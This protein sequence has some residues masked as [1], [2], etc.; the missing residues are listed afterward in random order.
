MNNVNQKNVNIYIST[1]I[2]VIYMAIFIWSRF[3]LVGIHFTHYDDLYVPY[4]FSVLGSYDSTYFGLQISKYGG[5]FGSYLAPWL[6]GFMNEHQLMFEALKKTLVPI[7]IA[8]SSTFAPLQFF[9]TAALINLKVSYEYS[10]I[11]SR[12]SSAI[13]SLATLI[14]F[15]QFAKYYITELRYYLLLVGGGLIAFSWMFLVYSSQAENYAAGPFSVICLFYIYAKYSQKNINLRDSIFLGLMLSILPLLH[16][17]ALFF[18]PGFYLGLMYSNRNS[19]LLKLRQ[20]APVVFI[21]FVIVLLTYYVFIRHSLDKSP[22]VGW[23]AGPNLQY[24]FNASCGNGPLLCAI[25]VFGNNVLDVV[26]SIVSFSELGSLVSVLYASIVI[27]IS[28]LGLIRILKSQDKLVS[29]LGVMISSVLLVWIILVLNKTLAFSPT[30]HSLVL[31]IPIAIM[32]SYGAYS[33]KSIFKS[34]LC[35]KFEYLLAVIFLGLAVLYILNFDHQ[36]NDRSDPFSQLNIKQ[37]VQDFNVGT[38]VT[39]GHTLNIRLVPFVMNEYSENFENVK[40]YLLVY[41][42]SKRNPD[43]IMVVCASAALC[44][45]VESKQSIDILN[46]ITGQASNYNLTYQYERKSNVLNCFGSKAG[47]G[48][49]SVYLGVWSKN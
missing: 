44:K 6:T 45:P 12:L 35:N 31:L 48:S 4:L 30:R 3:H 47:L 37:L 36:K 9:L 42:S 2:F 41:K 20:W 22:G 11:T 49:N 32:A 18:L 15:W 5:D 16:Y 8:K 33:I 13:F 43:S 17:Q 19:F 34:A 29:G 27:I 26:Q 46:H 7:A 23:N 1:F 28:I 25:N 21:N 10:L 14:M 40:P 38:I 39:Y 24:I